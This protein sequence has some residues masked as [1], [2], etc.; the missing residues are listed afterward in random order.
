VSIIEILGNTILIGILLS[1]FSVLFPSII[2][3]TPSP[4]IDNI[5]LLPTITAHRDNNTIIISHIKGKPTN[6]QIS[7]NGHTE[8]FRY[9]LTIGKQIILT[10]ASNNALLEIQDS[11]YNLLFYGHL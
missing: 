1:L 5:S 7:I 10:N 3:N 8:L 9:N 11:F 4:Q 6:I 2:L